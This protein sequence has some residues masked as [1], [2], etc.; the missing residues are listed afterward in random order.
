MRKSYDW[1][2]EVGEGDSSTG[3]TVTVYRAVGCDQEGRY[4][5]DADGC[6]RDG[7]IT[8]CVDPSQYELYR[9]E[10]DLLNRDGESDRET[11]TYDFESRC[12][13]PY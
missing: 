9:M 8:Q 12:A 4:F 3:E 2:E 1:L 6:Q 5:C 10:S 11:T 13:P 7:D